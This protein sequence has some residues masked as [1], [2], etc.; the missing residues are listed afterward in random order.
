LTVVAVIGAAT[1]LFAA[2]MAT[3]QNDIKRVLAY[4]TISQL[5]YMFLACGV[6]AFSAA[7]FHLMTHAFFK[8]LLFLGAGSV[9]HALHEEQ[10]LRNMGGLRRFL[11][12]TYLTF[13][14]A[15]LAIAGFPG[16]AGFVSK[17]EILWSSFASPL[18]GWGFWIVG[19]LT[20]GL[21]A[22][23]MFRLLFLAFYGAPRF[24][25]EK[26]AK[27]HESPLSMAGPLVILGLLSVV[28]GWIGWP[29]VLGGGNAFGRFLDPAFEKA[30]MLLPEST[31][32][33]HAT[34]YGLMALSVGIA[35]AG[36]LWAYR[37]YIR[38]SQAPERLKARFPS[39]YRWVLNK[40]YVDE[41]YDLIVVKPIVAGSRWLWRYFDDLLIDGAVNGLGRLVR[42]LGRAG[43]QAQT[44]YFRGYAAVFSL[45]SVILL[46]WM[47]Y[48]FR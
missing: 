34:E 40:Y 13:L 28:G 24:A 20:A 22:F 25:P 39:L 23:Y 1:A 3:V 48:V 11:P 14:A 29:A 6:A 26:A 38:P 31:H 12:A 33:T 36:F 4:S 45:G 41:F 18:G 16:F 19:V 17:D 47:I 43:A 35:A 9:I 42:G 32:H 8:A 30:R 7:I 37:W 15:T 44:G 5:G 2:T 21:T 27:V 46:A 10:D